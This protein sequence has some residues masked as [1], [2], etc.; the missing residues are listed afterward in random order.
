MPSPDPT[1]LPLPAAVLRHTLADGSAHFDLL[2]ARRTADDP[3]ARIAATWRCEADPST[4]A[5]GASCACT[6]IHDHRALYLT[7]AQARE[8]DGGRGRVEPVARGAWT[9]DGAGFVVR[10]HAG[11]ATRLRIDAGR[12]H[13]AP[14]A[15]T[16]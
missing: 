5:P 9:P 12:L 6:A 2:L 8:L 4:L 1:P 13:R 14:D 7:L 10:W 15:A 11:D 16:A 3:D